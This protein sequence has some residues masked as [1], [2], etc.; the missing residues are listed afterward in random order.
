MSKDG[1]DRGCEIL[2]KDFIS[3]EEVWEGRDLPYSDEQKERFHDSVPVDWI[4]NQCQ[5]NGFI[6][7]PG[8]PKSMTLLDIQALDNRYFD[9]KYDWYTHSDVRFSHDE[10][11]EPVWMA[12]RKDV[13]ENS[14]HKQ[15]SEQQKLVSLIEYVPNAAQTTWALTTYKVVRDVNLLENIYVRT[16]SHTLDG[17]CVKVGKFDRRGIGLCGYYDSYRYENVGILTGLKHLHE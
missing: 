6:L 7:L 3:P 5:S 14:T 17:N 4:L 15:W 2:G 13:L 11:V 8:P 16:A 9:S 12:V 10:T 1:Y